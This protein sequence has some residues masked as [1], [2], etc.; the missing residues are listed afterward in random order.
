MLRGVDPVLEMGW[1]K[2]DGGEQEYKLKWIQFNIS[3]SNL[4]EET[5]MRIER[6]K[7]RRNWII[8]PF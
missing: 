4:N 2:S 6:T 8:K 7:R 5:N 3:V 1:W